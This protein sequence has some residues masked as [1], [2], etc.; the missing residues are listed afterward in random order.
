MKSVIIIFIFCLAVFPT[1]AKST[2][3]CTHDEI[4][5]LVN[6]IAK[7]NKIDNLKTKTLVNISGDP[8]EYE[9]STA[10]IKNLISA[11]ILIAGPIELN[12]WIKKI[13][14]QRNKSKNITT[15]NLLLE[16]KDFK[17]YS[18]ANAET[19]SHFW[20]YPKIYCSLKTRLESEL[21]KIDFKI[22]VQKSCDSQSAEKTL[23][24][25]LA[26]TKAPIILTHDALLPLLLNLSPQNS[27]TIIAIKGSG[28]HEE[29]STQSIKKMYDALKAPQVIWIQ[30]AG[31]YIP[32]NLLNKVRTNDQVIKLDTSKSNSENPFSV[33]TD[34]AEKLNGLSG[35]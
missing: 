27:R 31:I 9:P 28:H 21:P 1:L 23:Q 3:F 19:L 6:I 15:I 12:P 22:K 35:K 14:F 20:L 24:S 29:A 30:E 13:N 2:I 10:Q 4:C 25:A 32:S 34:L 11:P 17:F 16:P 8:H 7:E 26:N 5:K 33:I 18:K